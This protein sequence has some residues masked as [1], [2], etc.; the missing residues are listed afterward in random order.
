MRT[1]RLHILHG[2]PCAVFCA[3][4]T[5]GQL[6]STARSIPSPALYQPQPSL[7]R[8]R[9][10]SP[11]PRHSPCPAGAV[12]VHDPRCDEIAP[13]EGCCSLPAESRKDA[14]ESTS[15]PDAPPAH[16]TAVHGQ[17]HVQP[18]GYAHSTSTGAEGR[19]TSIMGHGDR[20]SERCAS[21]LS[22]VRTGIDAGVTGKDTVGINA[23]KVTARIHL[24][25]GHRNRHTHADFRVPLARIAGFLICPSSAEDSG[26]SCPTRFRWNTRFSGSTWE[27]VSL[28]LFF[29]QRT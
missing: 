9:L 29:Y 7:Q 18:G 13:W 4:G 2:I 17:R 19:R 3:S 12:H 25:F 26:R 27:P 16:D 11:V 6:P 10:H 21:I 23:H 5:R 28:D 24:A 8:W 1:R 15:P 14:R 20:A 22:W